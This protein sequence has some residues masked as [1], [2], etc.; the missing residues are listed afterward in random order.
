MVGEFLAADV[1][2]IE[3]A[4]DVGVCDEPV[5]HLRT[6]STLSTT[7]CG[8]CSRSSTSLVNKRPAYI[9]GVGVGIK[10]TACLLQK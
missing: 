6:R 3:S 1:E 8:Y 7:A 5:I 9:Y 10:L 2:G 4:G